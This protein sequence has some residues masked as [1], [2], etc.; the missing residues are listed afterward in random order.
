MP[1]NPEDDLE[2]SEPQTESARERG[3]RVDVD[4]RQFGAAATDP[5]HEGDI[6]DE[7]PG[8]RDVRDEVSKPTPGSAEGE[9]SR[10]EQSR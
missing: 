8:H 3:H 4:N 6:A 2:R 9:R 5:H 10:D 7:G 1:I